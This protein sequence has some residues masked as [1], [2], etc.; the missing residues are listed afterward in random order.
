[1]QS[2]EPRVK[3][4]RELWQPKDYTHLRECGRRVEQKILE[5]RIKHFEYMDTVSLRAEKRRLKSEE[6]RLRKAGELEK[7]K[8]AYIEKMEKKW[9]RPGRYVKRESQTHP[10]TQTPEYQPPPSSPECQPPP[11]TPDD[12]VFALTETKVIQ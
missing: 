7:G 2:G 3:S 12:P 9:K 11:S 8:R 5:A 10:T 4:N 6:V 1:M